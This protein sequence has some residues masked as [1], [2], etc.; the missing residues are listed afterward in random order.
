MSPALNLPTVLALVLVLCTSHTTTI[1][2]WHCH[3]ARYN[4]I[5]ASDADN[6]EI[7]YPTRISAYGVPRRAG[8][9]DASMRRDTTAVV[10]LRSGAMPSS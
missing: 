5:G 6:G 3:D 10:A 4:R 8:K 9:A 2:R 1:F 7:Y